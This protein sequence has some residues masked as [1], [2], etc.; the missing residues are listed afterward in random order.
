[1]GAA[2][3]HTEINEQAVRLRLAITRTARRMRQTASSEL[4]IS[5]TASLAT[6][7]RF[8]PMTPSELASAESVQRP[9][10]TRII[11]R[12]EEL[13]LVERAPDP[14]DGR[15]SLISITQ[16]G[17]ALLR[18]LRE[19]KEAYLAS[20]LRELGERDLATLGRAAAILEQ[21]LAEE[22]V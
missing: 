13:D 19:R 3:N 11:G 12:L 7:E 4:G 2:V 5:A 1:M 22:R 15:C 16:G 10:A 18:Q 14:E 20:G 17:R 21:M 8:G 9:T 6:I